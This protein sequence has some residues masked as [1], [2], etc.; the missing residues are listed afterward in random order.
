M[1]ISDWSSDVCSSDLTTKFLRLG[2]H[3]QSNTLRCGE[4]FFNPTEERYLTPREYMRLHGFP[5][6]YALMAPVRGRSATVTNLDQH[7][8]VA[9]SVPPPVA[10]IMTEASSIQFTADQKR[11]RLNSSP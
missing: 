8:Q 5:D 2:R 10:R 4:I 9:N 6:D 3:K 1:R 7:R 11:T